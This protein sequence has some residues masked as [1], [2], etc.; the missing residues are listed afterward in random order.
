MEWILLRTRRFL[1]TATVDPYVV[2]LL[3]E[4]FLKPQRFLLFKLPTMVRPAVQTARCDSVSHS[5][6]LSRCC[7]QGPRSNILLQLERCGSFR[8]PVNTVIQTSKYQEVFQVM[9]KLHLQEGREQAGRFSHS[10][11]VAC[12]LLCLPPGT[13]ND[14]TT[15]VWSMCGT[16]ASCHIFPGCSCSHICQCPHPTHLPW[17]ALHPDIARH[18]PGSAR[19]GFSLTSPGI[20]HPEF[21]EMVSGDLAWRQSSGSRSSLHGFLMNCL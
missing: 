12:D 8:S 2:R 4:T 11:V 19:S 15:L 9:P 18:A 21:R 20:Q 13:A 3:P 16:H 1:G 7:Q 17:P 6:P 14:V 10:S 5:V